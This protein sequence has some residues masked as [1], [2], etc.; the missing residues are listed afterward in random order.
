MRLYP[1][2]FL[3]AACASSTPTQYAQGVPALPRAPAF[4]PT[5]DAPITTGQP[6]YVGPAE[7]LPHS[8][9]RRVLPETPDTRK[10]PGLWAAEPPTS[11]TGDV[12]EILGLALPPLDLDDSA[13]SLANQKD[14]ADRWAK[15][16]RQSGLGRQR[17]KMPPAEQRCA[18]ALMYV[19]CWKEEGLL[20]DSLRLYTGS[21]VHSLDF[22]RLQAAREA[23]ATSLFNTHCS[24][25]HLSPDGL[26][27]LNKARDAYQMQ[28][29][30]DRTITGGS[31]R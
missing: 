1:L 28:L 18:A 15:V 9:H 11:A 13:E 26:G 24:Q 31:K 22:Q 14:C 4:N 20:A 7:N 21:N 8:P 23:V 12:P 6:G 3:L 16:L 29:A 25:K 30:K 27:W 10:E 17:P 19:L 2:L 5:L